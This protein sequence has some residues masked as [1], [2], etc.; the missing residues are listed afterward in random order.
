MLTSVLLVLNCITAETGDAL[1]FHLL[2]E[3]QCVYI[4]AFHLEIKYKRSLLPL[5]KTHPINCG[6]VRISTLIEKK[7]HSLASSTKDFN[8]FDVK[9]STHVKWRLSDSNCRKFCHKARLKCRAVDPDL[10]PEKPC[11]SL[12]T[13]P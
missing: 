12:R 3:K 13:A 7:V 6:D 2:F 8:V 11:R 5:A 9:K 10:L 1:I 4:T